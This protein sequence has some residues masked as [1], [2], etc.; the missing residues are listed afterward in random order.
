MTVWKVLGER[1]F[2]DVETKKWY[3]PG[4]NRFCRARR[5]V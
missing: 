1:L 3:A 4:V 5:L 2:G